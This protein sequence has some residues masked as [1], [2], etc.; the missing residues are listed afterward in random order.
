MIRDIAILLTVAGI[1][2][3]YFCVFVHRDYKKSIGATIEVLLA[4]KL[5]F[6]IVEEATH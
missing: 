5:G 6:G 1:Y 2:N 4:K 3:P